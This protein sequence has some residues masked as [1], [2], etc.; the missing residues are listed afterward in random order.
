MKK[1]G[2]F[3]FLGKDFW[4]Y[5]VIVVVFAL[6]LL[7][8]KCVNFY[9][10]VSQKHVQQGNM[11]FWHDFFESGVMVVIMIISVRLLTVFSQLWIT[12]VQKMNFFWKYNNL[13][14]EEGKF[15]QCQI[16]FNLAN[17]K[18]ITVIEV[19]TAIISSVYTV[20]MLSVV[21]MTVPQ[22]I[23]AGMILIVGIAFGV[24]RGKMQKEADTIGADI[25][26]RQQLLATSYMIS[27]GVLNER[28]KE[29]NVIYW[30]QI[31]KQVVKN[32][33]QSLPDLVKIICFVTIMWSVTDY[34]L[35]EG[36]TPY[37]YSCIVLLAYGHIVTLA[38]DIGN[39]IEDISKII[40]YKNDNELKKLNIEITKKIHLLKEQEANVVVEEDDICITSEFTAD[41]TR[42]DGSEAVY[43][44]EDNLRIHKGEVILL[45]GENGTGKTR[46]NGIIK[47]L[48]P[49][50]IVYNSRTG[51]ES[52]FL[53]NFYYEDFPI[54]YILIKR[55]AKGLGLE[56]VPKTDTEI[57]RLRL[58]KQVNGADRQL[59]IALQIL[60]FAEKFH[61]NNKEKIQ[62]IILD[63]I[64]ANVSE[65]N[66]P[67]VV[68]FITD[69]LKKIGACTLLV[70]HSHKNVVF[71]YIN[72]TWM[73]VNKPNSK[74]TIFEK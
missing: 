15:K 63:E 60:Y 44:L 48:V 55:L 37:S 46:F 67:H 62:L 74:I 13:L 68:K 33:I 25:S 58:D 43:E 5:V 28:L 57:D 69:E 54:D 38:N 11:S 51:I 56:R 3:A 53:E 20:I 26:A 40:S 22:K 29:I 27:E 2:G 36:E 65:T 30:K 35:S 45:E 10:M 71:K 19:I 17:V 31:K 72:K 6:Y 21:E 39:I 59:L 7:G 18:A 23:G 16:A 24:K 34:V 73:M 70:S 47:E 50:T 1:N 14:Q 64:L 8:D 66:A 12:R 61:E 41:V 4:R 52:R 42:P 49:D 32:C 9:Y